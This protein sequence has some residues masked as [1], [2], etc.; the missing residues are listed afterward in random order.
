M[1]PNADHLLAP[2]QFGG[3]NTRYYAARPWAYF[4]LRL[5][6]LALMAGAPEKLVEIGREGVKVGRL[7]YKL[8]GDETAEEKEDRERFVLAES[9]ALVAHAGET[10]LRIY[11]AHEGRPECPWLEMARDRT[12]GEF[13]R[14]VGDRFPVEG[15]T[16]SDDDLGRVTEVFFG[17][18]R[19]EALTPT[20]PEPDWIAG[21]KN[22]EAF[23]RHFARD[24]LDPDLYNTL[25]HGFAV[26][27]GD[28]MME[29]GEGVLKA[30]GPAIEYLSRRR[31][32]AGTPRWFA[33]TRWMDPESNL[34]FTFLASRLIES[35]WAVARARYLGEPLPS[36]DLWLKPRYEEVRRRVRDAETGVFVD[37]MHME[38]LY[39]VDDRKADASGD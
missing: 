28:S 10:L 2:E 31:G 29:F 5:R 16:E 21:A 7:N 22:L 18:A 9:A 24:F 3:L 26:L 20:P 37:Q 6:A 15:E 11:L 1:K 12:P 34:A 36:I 23:L 19:R 32:K 27:P 38:L 30:E 35:L 13:K 39:Y 17:A 4:T 25:K 33:T 8:D 14:R